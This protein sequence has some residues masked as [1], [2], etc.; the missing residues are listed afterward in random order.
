MLELFLFIIVLIW[1]L[2]G[3]SDAKARMK[4]DQERE[5]REEAEYQR[6]QAYLRNHPE[7]AA[8]SRAFFAQVGLDPFE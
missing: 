5:E 4:Q 6:K 3:W 1:F 8:R 7:D 2:S